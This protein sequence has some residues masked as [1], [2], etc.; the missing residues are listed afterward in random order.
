MKPK[1]KSQKKTKSRRKKKAVFK[2]TKHWAIGGFILAMVAVLMETLLLVLG[3]IKP[4]SNLYILFV[5]V[6]YFGTKLMNFFTSYCSVGMAGS[7][8]IP[9]CSEV[10]YNFSMA[11]T[12]IGIILICF[13]IGAIIGMVYGKIKR[14]K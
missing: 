1:K 11:A 6:I 10:Y 7:G 8:E 12:M 13:C 5:P 3:P 9:L 2:K 4:E 14:I